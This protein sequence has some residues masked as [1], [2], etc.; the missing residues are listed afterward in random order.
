[1]M[2]NYFLGIKEK[3]LSFFQKASAAYQH[4]IVVMLEKRSLANC[5]NTSMHSEMMKKCYLHFEKKPHK[6][7]EVMVKANGV[8]IEKK[9]SFL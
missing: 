3:I 5:Q 9:I 2:K 4:V 1:M 7:L 8:C 6:T